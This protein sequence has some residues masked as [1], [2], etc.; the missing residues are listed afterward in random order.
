MKKLLFLVVVLTLV[1]TAVSAQPPVPYIGLFTD[2]FHSVWC[3]SNPAPF[4]PVEMW[5]WCLPSERGM[6]CAEFDISYPVNVIQSTVTLNPELGI[7]IPDPPYPEAF[8]LCFVDC[9]WDWAWLFHQTLYVV[10]QTPTYIEIIKHP[11][12]DIEHIR[13]ANCE[14][15]FPVEP[16]IKYTNMYL[17]YEP[18]DPECLGTATQDASW[19]AIK[20][21]ISE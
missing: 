1:A 12:P 19:G 5:V 6:I 16:C 15:G 2:E 10:D 13:F 17:N 14:P 9:K 7:I 18:P 20:S 11:D 4:Y 3:A 8:I 21:M